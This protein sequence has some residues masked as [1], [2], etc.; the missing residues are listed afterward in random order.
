M[1]LLFRLAV[2][3]VVVA[4]P[5]AAAD[6]QLVFSGENRLGAAFA[7][8]SLTRLRVDEPFLPIVVGLQNLSS[9]A[10]TVDRDTFRLIGPDRVRYP[11]AEIKDVRKGYKRGRID[12]R[13]ASAAG[14]P[15][16]VWYRQGRLREANFFPSLGSGSTVVDRISLRHNDGIVDLLYFPTPH[17]LALGQPL[18]LEFALAEWEA[19]LQLL[20]RLD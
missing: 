11:L 18:L 14:I 7:N 12:Q 2:V 3:F 6:P 17:G 9:D 19:P 4:A 15:M 5:A 8:V 16:D 20:I 13:L 1:R 10:A